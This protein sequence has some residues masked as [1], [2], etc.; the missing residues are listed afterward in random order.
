VL[1]FL[2]AYW[3]LTAGSFSVDGVHV[4]WPRLLVQRMT[5]ASPQPIG[6][7]QIHTRLARAFSSA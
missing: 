5:D 7:D 1:C 4:L 6:V 2:D 3:P